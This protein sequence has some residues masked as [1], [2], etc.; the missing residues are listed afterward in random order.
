MAEEAA[1]AA[2][3][4]RNRAR[5]DKELAAA[6]RIAEEQEMVRAL[7]ARKAEKAELAREKARMR[8]LLERDKRERFGGAAGGG[9]EAKKKEK[10]PAEMVEHGIKTVK[11]LY[12]ELRAP[13]VA[14]TCLKTVA[15]FIRNAKKDPSN[16]KFR[17]INLDNENVQ[18]RV[19]KINGGLA[20]LKAVGFKQ[21]DDGNYMQLA[22]VN[23]AVLANALEQLTPHI[24]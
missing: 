12:T 8:E 10:T 5:A 11:T 16:E 24:D 13:G 15:T 3:N 18:K 7:E 1:N 23:D 2:E 4:E 22:E 21:A 19:G 14:K 20:I 17:K 9:E 6:K